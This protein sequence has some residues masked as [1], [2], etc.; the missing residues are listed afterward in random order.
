[1]Y[2]AVRLDRCQQLA[3]TATLCCAIGSCLVC[4]VVCCVVG[5]LRAVQ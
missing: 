2:I 5:M 4:S 3:V 1:M